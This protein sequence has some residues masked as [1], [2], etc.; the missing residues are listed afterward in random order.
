MAVKH[1]KQQ[2]EDKKK[3]NTFQIRH[4]RKILRLRLPH[5]ISNEE[6]YRRTKTTQVIDVKL[7]N[8][9]NW[10]GRVLRMKNNR[11]HIRNAPTH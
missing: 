1:G 6:L 11:I 10:I 2:R 8:K 4:L 5:K 3:I 7:I 9:W